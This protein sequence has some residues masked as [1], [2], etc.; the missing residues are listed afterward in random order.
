MSEPNRGT[1]P[2]ESEIKQG[3]EISTASKWHAQQTDKL[4]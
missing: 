2:E 4:K 3:E 1:E